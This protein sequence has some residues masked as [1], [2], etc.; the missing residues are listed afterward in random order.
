[1]NS[2]NNTFGN[3]T[4]IIFAISLLTFIAI[5]SFMYLQS[6]STFKEL[7]KDRIDEISLAI[8]SDI[9]N[10]FPNIDSILRIGKSRPSV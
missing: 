6:I 7:L 4:V 9:T 1:M 5:L 3:K 10:N 8:S 2:T